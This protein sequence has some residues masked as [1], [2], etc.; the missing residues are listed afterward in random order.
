MG[1][2]IGLEETGQHTFVLLCT[3][4]LQLQIANLKKN[5]NGR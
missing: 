2:F 5:A 3:H 4:A 1:I